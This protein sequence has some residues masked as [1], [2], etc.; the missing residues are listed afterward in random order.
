MQMCFNARLLHLQHEL[1]VVCTFCQ[2]F[3]VER[4]ILT[5]FILLSLMVPHYLYFLQA[6]VEYLTSKL[7]SMKRS[8][9]E[10]KERFRLAV[11]ELQTKLH[12][13]VAG[14]KKLIE[15]RQHDMQKQEE[16]IHRLQVCF[17]TLMGGHIIKFKSSDDRVDRVFAF[18]AVD[19][20]LIPS[21]IEPI[22][23][24]LVF[25]A[26]SLNAQHLM[27]QCGEQAFKIICAVKKGS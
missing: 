20:G 19:A 11:E 14:R 10:Q 22:T 5:F 12:E 2:Y 23:L 15:L 9:E 26:S 8:M 6:Q 1:I 3:C 24:K 27:R 18:V 21:R 4:E 13:T 7:D 17:I 16:T 25:T